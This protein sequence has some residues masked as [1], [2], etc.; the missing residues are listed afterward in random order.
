MSQSIIFTR[1]QEIIE[2]TAEL[3]CMSKMMRDIDSKDDD[4]HERTW[5]T[6]LKRQSPQEF[7]WL[8]IMETLWV[9]QKNRILR[10][11]RDNPIKSVKGINEQEASQIVDSWMFD[12][13]EEI[14]TFSKAGRPQIRDGVDAGGK[15]A[16]TAVGSFTEFDSNLELIQSWINSKTL[17]FSTT[18][19]QTTDTALRAML[20]QSI[21]DGDGAPQMARQVRDV[22]ARWNGEGIEMSRALRIAR[23]ESTGAV[24]YGVNEGYK[25]SDVVTGNTWIAARDERTRHDHLSV[26]GTTVNLGTRFPIVGLEYPGDPSGSLG[27]IINCRCTLLAS[28]EKV[29]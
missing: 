22:F 24:N 15:L 29:D 18:V 14:G 10:N 3:I 12:M 1:R 5:Q 25:Q 23:T 11:M 8:A 2:R 28:F 21:M 20:K 9:G 19:N 16:L 26:S 27:Q 4:E 17:T 7:G 6:F 13:S